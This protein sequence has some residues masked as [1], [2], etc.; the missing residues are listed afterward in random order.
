MYHSFLLETISTYKNIFEN[1]SFGFTYDSIQGIHDNSL[2][3]IYNNLSTD[4]SS[5]YVTIIYQIQSSTTQIEEHVTE[6]KS[7]IFNIDINKIN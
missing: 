2:Q 1:I 7:N 5:N 6:I 4:L 3:L